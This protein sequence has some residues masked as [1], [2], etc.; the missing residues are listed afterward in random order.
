MTFIA[1]DLGTTTCKVQVFDQEGVQLG[2]FSE[3]ME[4]VHPRPDWAEQ[5]PADWWR[6]V[7]A[8]VRRCVKDAGG[9][10]EAIGIC[11]HRE[12]VL[13]VDGDGE[14][15]MPCILWADRRCEGEARE[16]G[17]EFGDDLHQRTGM[18]PDPYFTAPKLLWIARNSP[19]VM[20]Q[21]TKFLLP[22]DFILYRLTGEF[23][24]DWSLASR[25]MML[26][27]RA[28][29]W[30]SEILEYLGIDEGLMCSP[31][32]SASVVGEVSTEVRHELG[33]RGRTLVVAGAGDR[34]CEALGSSVS[35]LRAMESTG[36]ATNVSISTDL[37]PGRL[38]PDLLYS[39]HVIG[40]EYLVEQ[41]IGS[42]G[43]ALRWF[44]DNFAPPKK[45]E[46][47]AEPYGFID[48]AASASVP[49]AK[50]LLFLPFLMGAQATRWNP[51]A[52]GVLHGLTL[53]HGYGDIARA[54][55]EGIAF[56]IRASRDVLS[57]Q[58][59]DPTEVLA[60]GGAA[61]SSVWNQ[62]KA[63]ITGRTYS[64]P[65]FAQSASLGAMILGCRGFGI[66]IDPSKLNPIESQWVP[67]PGSSAEYDEVY[68][69]YE[70]LYRA[71]LG[72]FSGRA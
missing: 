45:E 55:W 25:T 7:V 33:L 19:E 67:D 12:S 53:G 60:L 52:R 28:K 43:L 63:D 50:E 64:R 44:R 38:E 11:S 10:V 26:D 30:W 62:I 51:D 31:G 8:G 4:T 20:A 40:G 47:E 56:E 24:T 15:I 17:A 36:S 9:D 49:G 5:D 3:E 23:S 66:D 2:T 58:A 22:K 61:R 72:V 46:F 65:R 69:R 48:R 13:A 29:R 35:P 34:Q 21:V 27:I 54:I 71:S 32:E 59:M 18:K 16:L 68:R 70:R 41:G 39:C 42:T 37:L 14:V 1:I 6:S 57:G